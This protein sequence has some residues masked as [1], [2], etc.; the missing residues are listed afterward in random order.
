MEYQ[1]KASSRIVKSIGKELIADKV[2]SIVELVKNSYDADASEVKIEIKDEIIYVEDNGNGMSLDTILNSWLIPGTDNKEKNRLSP[3]GRKVLGAKGLGRYSVGILGD[4][5]E[6]KTVSNKKKVTLKINWSDFEKVKYLEDVKIK[7]EEEDT[8]EKNGTLLK[9][10]K[11][12]KILDE[13][14]KNK[15]EKELR[16]LVSPLKNKEDIF[17]IKLFDNNLK[18][19]VI[20]ESYISI[21]EGFHYR[22]FGKVNLSEEEF[23]LKFEYNNFGKIIEYDFSNNENILKA[24]EDIN[25]KEKIEFDFKVF[26]RENESLKK[27]VQEDS[28]SLN[29]IKKTLDEICGVKIYRENFRIRPYGDKEN[30]W[31]DLNRER[32]QNPTQRLSVNQI[33]GSIYIEDIE[34]SVLKEKSARDGLQEEDEFF[35][36]K[37]SIQYLIRILENKR[38]SIRRNLQKSASETITEKLVQ[39][40][41]YKKLE[42]EIKSKLEDIEIPDSKLNEISE[43]LY[44]KEKE[45]LELIKEVEKRFAIYERQITLGKLVEVLM[46]ESS[47]YLNVLKS[48]PKYLLLKLKKMAE[49]IS[50]ERYLELE[51]LVLPIEKYSNMLCTLFTKIRPLS[52]RKNQKVDFDLKN[53]VELSMGPFEEKIKVE[54]IKINLDILEQK[55]FGCEEDFITAFMN[56]IENSIYWMKSSEEKEITIKS[57]KEDEKLIIELK[58][59]GVGLSEEQLKESLIF[60]PG[61]SF[62]EDGTGL[63]L[64]ISG[65]ALKRNG[66]KLKGISLDTGACFR[67]EE[68]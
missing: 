49:E 35:R 20:L 57:Y 30:D 61:I 3:N 68:E 11:L 7:I 60:E 47:K 24:I 8:D 23:I 65:E 31:L 29:E 22:M 48:N 10:G 62:K 21:V 13:K 26:D 17:D 45:N 53:C 40:S 12:S 25:F 46:H 56:L 34:N 19:F 6:L 52:R 32:V 15:L 14:E 16:L 33:V 67:M 64:P 36:L 5:L 27:L 50:T 1:L 4:L 18:E 41:S 44:K 37:R 38:F 54:K 59:T 9:I 39:I 42:N 51:K 66:F 2:A 43:I 28:L 63:G 55:V 58:D